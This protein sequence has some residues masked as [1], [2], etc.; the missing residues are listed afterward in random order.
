MANVRSFADEFARKSDDI[1]LLGKARKSGFAPSPR[2]ETTA[3][4]KL[5]GENKCAIVRMG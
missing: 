3:D 4:F 2:G 1:Y 5:G